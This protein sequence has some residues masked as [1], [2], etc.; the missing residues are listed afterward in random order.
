MK[1]ISLFLPLLLCV[2]KHTYVWFLS[3][4]SHHRLSYNPWMLWLQWTEM[5]HTQITDVSKVFWEVISFLYVLFL[6]ENKTKLASHLTK[7]P[8]FLFSRISNDQY[9]LWP[10]QS[11]NTYPSLMGRKVHSKTK[12]TMALR[13]VG[14]F[15][16]NQRLQESSRV[17]RVNHGVPHTAGSS[18]TMGSRFCSM[19]KS[20]FNK[21]NM[22]KRGRT[23]ARE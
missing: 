13:H 12:L 15:H 18:V 8:S 11:L 1:Y 6:N 23:M 3:F 22:W 7:T 9:I 20:T 5:G 16:I 19:I 17:R 4:F 2:R 21:T 10:F 14:L